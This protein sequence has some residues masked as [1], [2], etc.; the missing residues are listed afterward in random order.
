MRPFKSVFLQKVLNTANAS[1]YEGVADNGLRLFILC[2]QARIYSS[3]NCSY[4]NGI[5]VCVYRLNEL[6]QCC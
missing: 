2:E 4:K 6:S 5:L 1:L 3:H